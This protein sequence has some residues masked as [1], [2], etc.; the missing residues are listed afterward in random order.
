MD[1]DNMLGVGLEQGG[2][3]QRVKKKMDNISNALTNKIT[4]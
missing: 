1:T 3:G 2:G 4:K